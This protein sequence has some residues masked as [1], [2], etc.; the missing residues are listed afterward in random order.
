MKVLYILLW[1]CVIGW[2]SCQQQTALVNQIGGSY[3]NFMGPGR[4]TNVSYESRFSSF[5]TFIQC[6]Q[7][8]AELRDQDSCAQQIAELACVEVFPANIYDESVPF[9]VLKACPAFVYRVQKN[10]KNMID[11]CLSRY[12]VDYIKK[13]FEPRCD[14]DCFCAISHDAIYRIA[15]TDSCLYPCKKNKK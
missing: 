3:C 12:P 1:S 9:H 5:A 4:F 2:V 8:L 10:C 7:T 15:I 11:L 13:I 14:Q 6:T